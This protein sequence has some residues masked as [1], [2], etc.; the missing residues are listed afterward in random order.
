MNVVVG[1]VSGDVAREHSGI[2]RLH[3]AADKRDPYPRHRLHAEALEHD[4]VAVPA[5]DEH[6]IL[7]DRCECVVHG[8]EP[9]GPMGDEATR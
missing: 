5:T 9:D 2:W 7:D 8:I 6:E 1:V 3:V 4:D